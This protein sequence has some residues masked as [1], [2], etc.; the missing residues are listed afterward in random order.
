M[1]GIDSASGQK[2]WQG[3]LD[4][5]ALRV[6][7][8]SF[9]TW[10]KH[11]DGGF[12]EN[13]D[14][15]IS[16]PNQFVAD[17][18]T[19]RYSDLIA[20]AI[21]ELSGNNLTYYFTIVGPDIND[22]QTEMRLQ[23][24]SAAPSPTPPTRQK[25]IFNGR[26]RF[27]NFI[28]GKYNQLAHAAALAV[29][30]APGKTKYNPLLVYGGTG[31]GK[32]HLAQAIGHFIH[33][34]FPGKKAIYATSEKFTSDFINSISN[35][36][37]S[38]FTSLYRSADVLLI[39]DI[40]FFS[41]KEST[42]EQFFHTF[43]DLFHSGRQIV[44]TADR[45]PRDIKGLEERLLSR[46]SSGLVADL[47]PPDLETKIAILTML[48][49]R[50]QVT[51]A[52]EVLYYIAGHVSSNIRELE[53]SLTRLLAYAS[54]EK[55]EITPDFTVRVLGQSLIKPK[56]EPGI[57]LI[58]KKTAEFFQVD[59]SSMTARKKTAR[60][61]FARQVAMYL[62]RQHTSFSLKSIGEAFGGR[63]HSTVIHACEIIEAKIK[64][65]SDLKEKI[66]D[67]SSALAVG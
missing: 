33:E 30:E 32:T 52:E 60:I 56:K 11:T 57:K 50:E 29:A 36:R 49:E 63:D 14:V 35:K 7:K 45:H 44:M 22:D 13:G 12:D 15:K 24:K 41:G 48:T 26:Y 64:D 20:E 4:Y 51:L 23:I 18:L 38:D 5:M 16:V 42:Q 6:K 65:N 47:Q 1:T 53:G 25:S 17:W 3:C 39:D 9:S 28:V 46:F 54:L 40:Q 66:D 31:L 10:F 34:E 2:M 27:D 61:A 55:T 37:V 58:Q 67:L 19:D 21:A 8:H 43:N 62:V 59:S